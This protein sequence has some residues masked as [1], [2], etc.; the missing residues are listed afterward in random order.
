MAAGGD[1]AIVTAGPTP[2]DA[3]AVLKLEGDVAAE[4]EAV[5]AAL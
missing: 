3:D 4:L 1:V 5:L 2:Y